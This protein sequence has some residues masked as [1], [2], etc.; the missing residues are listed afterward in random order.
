MQPIRN[1]DG[2]R[3]GNKNNQLKKWEEYFE[4]TLKHKMFLGIKNRN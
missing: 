3:L 4:E 1:K 2:A